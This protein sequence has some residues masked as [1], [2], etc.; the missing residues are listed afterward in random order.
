MEKYLNQFNLFTGQIEKLPLFKPKQAQADIPTLW[1]KISRPRLDDPD[2]LKSLKPL[3]EKIERA[4]D[5]KYD[6]NA[7]KLTQNLKKINKKWKWIRPGP[8]Y[9]DKIEIY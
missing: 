7:Q 9:K 3:I 1:N 8:Y 4:P 5:F 6:D 2:F